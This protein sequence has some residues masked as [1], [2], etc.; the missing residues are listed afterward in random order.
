MKLILLPSIFYPLTYAAICRGYV[1]STDPMLLLIIFL[2]SAVPSA[3]F[4]VTLAQL[5][6]SERSTARLAALYLPMYLCS[7]ATMTI[8]VGVALWLI[9][10]VLLLGS[11]DQ[12]G[13]QLR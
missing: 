9:D 3:Q 13:T 6:L 10:G 7:A 2:Q 1:A 5:T 12:V 4:V 11:S 8:A